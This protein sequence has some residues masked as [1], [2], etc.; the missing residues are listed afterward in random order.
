ML[1]NVKAPVKAMIGPWDHDFPHNA[2]HSPQM[3]WRHEA[4]RWFDHW[5]KDIDSGILDEPA[6]AVYVRDW[7]PPGP[8]VSDFPG[9]WR[10]E[11]GWPIRRTRSETWFAQGQNGLARTMAEEST[12]EKLKYVPSSGLEAGGPVMWW[13]SVLPDLQPS[14][15]H[16]LVFDSEPLKKPLE[17]LGSPVAHLRVSAD[18]TRANWIAR[19]AD[20]APDGRVTHVAAAAF[21]GSHR[22]SAR[23]PA[24]IVPGEEFP[25]DIEMHFTSWVF[26]AGHRIRF[27]VTNAQWPMLWPTPYPMTTTL[28]LGGEEGA[29]VDLPVMPP[30][31]PEEWHTP[32]FRK[33]AKDPQL[34]GF[35]S[36]DSGNSTGYGEI[37][38]VQHDP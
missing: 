11:D 9:R 28:A 23:T 4:V 10:W 1:E 5:L 19:I 33:P 21:N 13:G 26:P 22:E 17:I 24:A 3:E 32:A 12:V 6:F 30:L 36:L 7:H 35:T 34:P 38:T 2:S 14:D 29:R 16:A 25:L 31:S 37:E 15:D 8:G 18:A 27:A 20:V